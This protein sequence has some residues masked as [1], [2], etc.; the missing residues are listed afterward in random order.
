M[1]TQWAGKI[2]VN[3]ADA[4]AY[5]EGHPKE[6]VKPE[7]VRASHILIAPDPNAADP[8]QAK[9]VAKAKAEALLTQVKSGAD[10]AELAKANSSC[11]S[12][13]QGGDLGTFGRGKMVKPFEDAAFAL[14]PGEV[15]D[16]VETR[17]GYHIIK[18]TEHTDA[19]T[20][21]LEEAKTGIIERLI[22][23]KKNQA[24]QEYLQSL[25]DK[26]TIVYAPGFEPPAP[27]P[28]PT[29]PTTVTPTAPAPTGN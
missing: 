11:P 16:V 14:E 23:Q 22:A 5:Y 1:E 24:V 26:A 21:P 12:K 17:F 29:A 28:V 10:F 4:Q 7:M 6:F 3:D 8:N 25:K 15:S 18:V 27:K 2:D 20:V 19:Q 9:A 13:T